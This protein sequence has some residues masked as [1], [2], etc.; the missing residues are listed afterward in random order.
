MALALD[1]LAQMIGPGPGREAN[2]EAV[3]RWTAAQ[4]KDAPATRQV[5]PGVMA[6]TEAR[7]VTVV[8]EAVGL[9]VG[10]VVEFVLV[11]E[12][13]D[14]DYEALAVVLARP[15]DVARALEAIGLPRGRPVLP[16][17]FRFWP[18]GERVTLTARP[19]AGGPEHPVGAYVFDQPAQRG[20][21]NLFTYV[22]SV[23]RED[24]SCE[25]DEPSPGSIISTYNA[26]TT[27]LDMPFA[28]TQNAAYGHYVVKEKLMARETLWCFIF[29]PER[30]A[31]EPPRVVPVELTAQPRAGLA[32]PPAGVAE[33]E[34]VRRVSDGAVTTNALDE[35]VK[36][37]MGL[38]Q[39]GREPFVALRFDDR[40]TVRA[41]VEAARVIEA[42][43]GGNGVRVDGPAAGQL[44]YKAFL[45][46]EAW[47][48]Q[49][50]RL[51]QP[52]ELRLERDGEAGWRKT[53]VQIHEDW[54]DEASLD[55]KLTVRPY[56][57][58]AWAELPARVKELGRGLGTLLV[59]APA[60][61]PLAAFM[62]GV[63]L[64]QQTLPTVYVF[65]E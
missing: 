7:T 2:Q 6:D 48:A 44:Y 1:A 51:M 18:K 20:M 40:L 31:D 45:P 35:T 53:F 11:G 17:A 23:W 64:V 30:S 43:E 55:P 12:T 46:N 56:P 34:W 49:E 14:R 22:G 58:Q 52:Y 61:A 47:R 29:R 50:K 9:D 33:V 41:A 63:R 59:F 3:K 27:V 4:R 57:L 15:S 60:D 28:V 5:W 10:G 16:R 13:S 38:T 26:P 65:A 54:S 62:A 42:I 37:F 32:Q 39:S 36:G 8:A 24:G 21:S 19:F 25:A